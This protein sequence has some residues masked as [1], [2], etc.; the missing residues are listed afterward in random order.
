VDDF[1]TRK[2]ILASVEESIEGRG[3]PASIVI[4]SVQS[5]GNQRLVGKNLE[6]ISR[7]RGIPPERATLQL[8]VEEKMGVVAIYHAMWEEDVERAMTHHL[9]SV[10]SDG[11][12]GT[13]PHPRT[14]GTFPRIISHF[15]RERNLFSLEDA[16]RKMTSA[17]AKRLNLEDRG[18][19]AAGAHADLVIFDPEGFRDTASYENPKQFASGLD[20]VF[21]NGK[22]LLKEGDVRDI[23]AGQLIRRVG[24]Q[25]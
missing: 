10:G 24:S 4:A 22:P 14:Y 19:I 9:H 12:L 17:P 18:R 16:I 2:R 23:R 25:T 20:W 7:E 15:A 6:E 3:G 1:Q 21:V 5:N 11:I 8:L 13:F